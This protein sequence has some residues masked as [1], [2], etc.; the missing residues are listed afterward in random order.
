MS[1]DLLFGLALAAFLAAWV[2]WLIGITRGRR[3]PIL[4]GAV[5]VLALGVAIV[6]INGEREDQQR[7]DFAEKITAYLGAVAE[8]QEAV[9]E[10]D[11]AYIEPPEDEDRLLEV[12][13]VDEQ[14]R[15]YDGGVLQET[16][17]IEPG[18]TRETEDSYTASGRLGDESYTLEV[19]R[20][21]GSVQ[22]SGSCDVSGPVAT[23][24]EGTWDPAATAPPAG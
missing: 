21:G 10:A 16:E 14:L 7:E 17:T 4:G 9:Y 2:G 24:V 13:G 11:G 8:K 1:L 6:L 15:T 22:R 23:C 19:S 5:A 3:A 20:R 12:L 18:L